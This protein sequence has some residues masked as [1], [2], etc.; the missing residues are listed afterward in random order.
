[1]RENRRRLE[2][3][4][5]SLSPTQAVCLWLTEAHQHGSL[6]AYTQ[7]LLDQPDDTYPLVKMPRQVVEAV[8]TAM[9]GKPREDVDREIYC[10]QRDVLF[11]F[12]LAIGLNTRA[13]EIAQTLRLKG[14][15]L[16][17]QFHSLILRHAVGR[18][19]NALRLK[20]CRELAYPLDAET[21]AV[22]EA[23]QKYGVETWD[24]LAEGEVLE[25]WVREQYVC[26]GRIELPWGA[27]VPFVDPASIPLPSYEV[28]TAE[29][30]RA[31]FLDEGAF[32]AFVEMTD[33]LGSGLADVSDAAFQA[34]CAV[35]SAALAGLA[36]SGEVTAGRVLRLD[37]V[38]HEYLADVPLVDDKWVDRQVLV[39]A[40]YGALLRKHGYEVRFAD[41]DH[42]QAWSRVFRDGCEIAFEELK[43]LLA[44][45][46]RHLGKC[47]AEVHLIDDRP[48]V[49]LTDYLKWRGRG[50][51][52]NLKAN[53]S[54]GLVRESFNAWVRGHGLEGVAELAGVRV[55][56]IRDYATDY[57]IQ[58]TSDQ[59]EARIRLQARKDV[60]GGLRDWSLSDPDAVD[61]C[62]T[63]KGSWDRLDFRGLVAAWC[64]QAETLLQEWGQFSA[65]CRLIERRY[66]AGH[67]VLYPEVAQ[68]L[69]NLREGTADLV[70][71]VNGH[72]VADWE[73]SARPRGQPTDGS[74]PSR[75]APVDVTRILE[76]ADGSHIA[77]YLVDVAK[78]EALEKLGERGKAEAI[79]EPHLRGTP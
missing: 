4:T 52:G 14:L 72:Y 49:S 76:A 37:T 56:E 39:L 15:L 75:L 58:V 79:L 40:E 69:E 33:H 44:E 73:R 63:Q 41:D 34:R 27:H 28:P 55:E 43:P 18:D 67:P 6:F 66:F 13:L 78:G 31:L 68:T 62:W 57:P 12:Q 71:L 74:N 53:L 64:G 2:R 54:P 23:A 61:W 19:T 9:K 29:E 32:Q 10:V 42:P 8:R 59:E 45:A 36:T 50:V 21:A 3:I 38:P 60:L 46:E 17:E 20:L 5:T 51:K 7:W 1:M 26:E 30:I 16:A 70:E 65:T 77:R 25:E 22:V 35:L 11:L 24:L 48:Y 47:P